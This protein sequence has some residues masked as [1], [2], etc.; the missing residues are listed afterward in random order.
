MKGFWKIVGM[1]TL[2]AII[3][4]AGISS[5]AAQRP[6]GDWQALAAGETLWYSFE[7]AGDGSQI[8]VW[9]DAEPDESVTVGIWTGEQVRL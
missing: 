2:V 6:S 8:E 5:A 3:G 7:Y 1:V 4:V 9:L